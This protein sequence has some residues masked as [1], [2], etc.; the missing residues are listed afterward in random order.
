MVIVED[1][2]RNEARARMNN[3]DISL[4]RNC[5]DIICHHVVAEFVS[6][7][8][9]SSRTAPSQVGLKLFFKRSPWIT[10]LSALSL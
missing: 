6:M 5:L 10:A 1:E 7:V 9:T 4:L 2:R 3:R 8:R